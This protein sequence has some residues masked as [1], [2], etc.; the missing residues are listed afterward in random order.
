[1][2]TRQETLLKPDVK[3]FER[4][5]VRIHN[6]LCD[7]TL[8]QGD[9]E[10]LILRGPGHLLRRVNAHVHRK[11]LEIELGGGLTERIGD[12][13]TTI[14]AISRCHKGMKRHSSYEGQA[15]CCVA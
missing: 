12:A 15:I 14:Y 8:S 3:D 7:L 4:L 13:F 9:E 11:S 1:M 10:A 5:K 6:H 2:A